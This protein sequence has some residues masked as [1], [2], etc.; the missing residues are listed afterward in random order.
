M[1]T[2]SYIFGSRE[3][4]DTDSLKILYRYD[5]IF[6]IWTVDGHKHGDTNR[7]IRLI[8]VIVSMIASIFKFC[9]RT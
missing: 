8:C 7:L 1:H 4:K 9:I 2:I 6:Q 3:V 5:V